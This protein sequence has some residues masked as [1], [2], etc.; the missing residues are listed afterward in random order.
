MRRAEWSRNRGYMR[1]CLAISGRGEGKVAN[2][3]NKGTRR[4][5]EGMDSQLGMKGSGFLD[6]HA[7][8]AL[9]T[10]L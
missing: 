4:T 2:K 10:N 7:T 1:K 8:L 6:G 3:S 9:V 5:Y